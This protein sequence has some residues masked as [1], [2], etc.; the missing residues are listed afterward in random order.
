MKRNKKPDWRTEPLFFRFGFFMPKLQNLHRKYA[1]FAVLEGVGAKNTE[2]ELWHK[3][4]FINGWGT[5]F[6][7]RYV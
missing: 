5:V 6:A 2:N 7:M 3:F 1:V 4:C